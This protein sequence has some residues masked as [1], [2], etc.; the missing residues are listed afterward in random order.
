MKVNLRTGIVSRGDGPKIYKESLFWRYVART[1]GP[2]WIAKRMW[3]D[4]HLVDDMQHYAR[5]RDG[6]I[7]LYQRDYAIR[8]VFE[9]YNR[10]GK[11]SIEVVR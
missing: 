9:D 1:L 3:K 11:V 4:G 2:K 10:T 6:K 8:S 5:T 7:A